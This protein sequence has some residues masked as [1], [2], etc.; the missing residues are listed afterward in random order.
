MAALLAELAREREARHGRPEAATIPKR[1]KI[2]VI[3]LDDEDVE[4]PS[5]VLAKR[6]QAEEYEKLAGG[7]STQQPSAHQLAGGTST[8][9][10]HDFD[11]DDWEEAVP[12]GE[13]LPA[14]IGPPP[15]NP[16]GLDL[17]R[18][19]ILR[20][21]PTPVVLI[22]AVGGR[23]ESQARTLANFDIS[24]K[25]RSN[26]KCGAAENAGLNGKNC[27][28]T[29]HPLA[30]TNNKYDGKCAAI[31]P[32]QMAEWVSGVVK[33]AMAAA[34]A[35]LSR[36]GSTAA[37]QQLAEQG[38]L[39]PYATAQVRCLQ[40]DAP[41]RGHTEKKEGGQFHRH[42]DHGQY[43]WV[44]LASLHA[45]SDFYVRLGPRPAPPTCGCGLPCKLSVSTKEGPNQGRHCFSCR[46]CSNTCRTFEW[47]KP[48]DEVPSAERVLRLRHGDLLIFDAA[49]QS[50]VE[51]GVDA[52][53]RNTREPQ[54]PYRVS[55]QW[56]VTHTAVSERL[57]LAWC[58]KNLC[59]FDDDAVIAALDKLKVAPRPVS[60]AA[61]GAAVQ[62]LVDKAGARAK[63]PRALQK[64]E[65]LV[66]EVC[67][68][69]GNNRFLAGRLPFG[70]KKHLASAWHIDPDIREACFRDT[71]RV[72]ATPG[73][74]GPLRGVIRLPPLAAL[75][76]EAL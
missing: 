20:A 8:Q 35:A 72:P 2:E 24:K 5:V 10:Q 27:D 17:S 69:A 31:T 11:E 1:Q 41:I 3:D 12:A 64:L 75:G 52:I 67:N 42:L 28:N 34:A 68:A 74:S 23:L 43:G 4:D 59:D 45:D 6:L 36:G 44:V 19:E 51:H 73:A 50:D 61:R 53:Y 62:A 7:T 16:L 66:K 56:R 33:P 25:A 57:Q 55:V 70:N 15:A 13:M 46:G 21:D 29:F 71:V 49:R 48:G 40:Y 26:R 9:H 22:R 54:R 38:E 76:M 18:V 47:A 14:G 39:A 65:S 37:A 32:Q 63:H 30:E 58:A 60:G